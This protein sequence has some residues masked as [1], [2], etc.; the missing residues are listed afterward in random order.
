MSD[1]LTTGQTSMVGPDGRG[2]DDFIGNA[3]FDA[4]YASVPPW[5]TGQPQPAFVSAADR[6]LLR[7]RLLDPGCGTGELTLLASSLGCDVV[8]VDGSVRAINA[9]QAK[10]LER[11]LDAHF[12]V[13]DAVDLAMLEGSFDT[14]ADSCFLH[15]LDDVHRARYVQR[16][17]EITA[18]D[19]QML[20][21]VMSDRVPGDV[22]P[23]RY[24]ASGIREVFDADGWTVAS[25]DDAVIANSLGMEL[26]GLFA[27]INRTGR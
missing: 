5:E 4:M 21:L 16:L 24:S 19:A 9:A 13:G 2:G 3:D 10:G 12:E 15:V 26:P 25:I 23:R 1:E 8:G 27:M 6:G 22:G 20:L 11:G 17:L 18:P 7:G 14:I